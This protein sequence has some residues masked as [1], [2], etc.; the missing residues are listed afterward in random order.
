M[1][2]YAVKLTKNPAA[3][4][5]GDINKLRE[6]GLNDR[7]ILDVN[8]VVSY[9]NYVNRVADGLGIELEPEYI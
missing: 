4:N 2:D 5:E 7:D 6:F 8:Q 1:L 9:F 3:V